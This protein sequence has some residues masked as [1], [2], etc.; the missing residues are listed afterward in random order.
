MYSEPSL[1]VAARASESSV[2]APPPSQDLLPASAYQMANYLNQEPGGKKDAPVT[3]DPSRHLYFRAASMMEHPHG[4]WSD[5][6][7]VGLWH[8][9]NGLAPTDAVT[10][11][12]VTERWMVGVHIRSVYDYPVAASSPPLPSAESASGRSGDGA[13]SQQEPAHAAAHE[14][15]AVDQKA[16]VAARAEREYGVEAARAIER[17]RRNCHWS[18]FLPRIRELLAA[19]TTRLYVAADTEEAYV[20]LARHLGGGGEMVR[21]PRSCPARAACDGRDADSQVT[22][23]VDMLNLARTGHILGSG[24][25]SYSEMASH[26]GA[27][28]PAGGPLKTVTL[29]LAGRDFGQI[30]AAGDSSRDQQPTLRPSARCPTWEDVMNTG[31]KWR[32][33]LWQEGGS[34]SA[35]NSAPDGTDKCPSGCVVKN[36]NGGNQAPCCVKRAS[37]TFAAECE[38]LPYGCSTPEDPALAPTTATTATT[39]G[40][41]SEKA[42]YAHERWRRRVVVMDHATVP[43]LIA[44]ASHSSR[45][46]PCPTAADVFNTPPATR[47]KLWEDRTAGCQSACRLV[48]SVATLSS[49]LYAPACIVRATTVWPVPCNVLPVGCEMPWPAM[50]DR[51]YPPKPNM[52]LEPSCRCPNREDVMNTMGAF[53]WRLW[54]DP[55]CADGCRLAKCNNGRNAPCCVK[56]MRAVYKQRCETMPH[57][58]FNAS[59]PRV[60]SHRLVVQDERA[61][62]AV[63]RRRWLHIAHT[64]FAGLILCTCV[65]IAYQYLCCTP[66]PCHSSREAAAVSST[67]C[68]ALL[69]MWMLW[70]DAYRDASTTPWAFRW[71]AASSSRW[72]GPGNSSSSCMTML[73]DDPQG[74]EQYLVSGQVEWGGGSGPSLLRGLARRRPASDEP[75]LLFAWGGRLGGE[76]L[77]VADANATQAYPGL[78]RPRGITL[79]QLMAPNTSEPPAWISASG[80][81]PIELAAPA[82]PWSVEGETEKSGAGLLFFA[83]GS[84]L[85]LNHFLAEAEAAARTFREHN[86]EIAIAVVTN[87]ETV[88]RHVFSMHIMPRHDLLFRGGNVDDGQARADKIP[89]QWFTRLYYMAHSPFRLTWAL[90]ARIR[91]AKIKRHARRASRLH[92]TRFC[93]LCVSHA[94]VPVEPAPSPVKLGCALRSWSIPLLPMWVRH[95][96]GAPLQIRTWSHALLAPRAAF[97]RR[98]CA[99]SYGAFTS[100]TPRSR[101]T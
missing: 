52:F 68:A 58:C 16:L 26:I 97:W 90:G 33:D 75:W 67:V 8:L 29:E 42:K 30:L 21:T 66:K 70:F 28:G 41:A 57:G 53:R 20:G 43:R 87:N 99:H 62:S 74:P 5:P 98:H 39:A 76:L 61:V 72:L 12:V 59:S 25:S 17:W 31:S 15:D 9:L 69:L 71:R 56:R 92:A 94:L 46:A 85:T 54:D 36:C 19:R 55:K 7:Q 10:Q 81:Q 2:G 96:C 63:R 79:A 6:E 32:W 22:A 14:G 40:V 1:V 64:A 100:P 27:H 77:Q 38:A 11:R 35:T 101:S 44:N 73:R 50:V 13:S 86:P 3:L 49:A 60:L 91:A 82:V 84:R 48:G 80:F 95:P 37:A 45:E 23:L 78:L 88:D 18:K 47:F 34:P 51:T 89:R 4:A 24:H 65:A 93:V 83:Y